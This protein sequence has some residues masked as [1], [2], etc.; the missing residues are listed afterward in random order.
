[1]ALLKR[2]GD[3]LMHMKIL[4]VDSAKVL[5]GSAN[6]TRDSL[7]VYGNLVMGFDSPEMA[8]V[9]EEKAKLLQYDGTGQLRIQHDFTVGMQQVE[10]WFLPDNAGAIHRIEKLLDTAKKTVRI[11]MFAWTRRDLASSVAAA[12]RRG[13]DVEVVI[14]YNFGR[15]SGAHIV[16]F[17]KNNDV[18]VRLS[19]SGPMLHHKF[20]YIDG[21]TLVNGSANWTR[22]AFRDNNDCFIVVKGL[23]EAQRDKMDQLWNTIY[24]D[25]LPPR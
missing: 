21:T 17:L 20:L 4:V 12:H 11:A 5:I 6:M 3:G 9:I 25:A 15:G 16:K 13:V 24:N 14:D 10:L 23:S 18:K 7:Q 1:V 2:Y 19:R 8:A 22:G